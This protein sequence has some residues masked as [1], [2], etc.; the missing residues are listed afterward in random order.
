M[1]CV[2]VIRYREGNKAMTEKEIKKLA[3]DFEKQ[4]EVYLRGETLMT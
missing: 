4:K 2:E 3:E 1:G